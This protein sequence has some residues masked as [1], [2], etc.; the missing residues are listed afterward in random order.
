MVRVHLLSLLFFLL[1][2]FS[3]LNDKSEC[4]ILKSQFLPYRVA[5]SAKIRKKK[6]QREFAESTLFL[7]MSLKKS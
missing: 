6:I 2:S 4:I 7:A 3:I 1:F 5:S